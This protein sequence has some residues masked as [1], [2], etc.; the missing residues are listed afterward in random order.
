MR[1]AVGLVQQAGE[2]VAQRRGLRRDGFGTRSIDSR[3]TVT[4][5]R[6]HGGRIQRL[7]H[8]QD[9]G[10]YRHLRLSLHGLG[11]GM[12]DGMPTLPTD[13]NP[14][15]A[16]PAAASADALDH[17]S[18]L[19]QYETDC[20]D[21]HAALERRQT[22]FVVLDVRSPEVWA[23]GHVPGAHSLPHARITER[24]LAS[25]PSDVVFVVYCNGPHCNGADRAAIALA[26][27]GRPVKKMIGGITGWLDEGFAL[28]PTE[29]D[30]R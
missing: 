2:V 29:A 6:S 30:A 27:L 16:V 21:V 18:R 19:L 28:T 14:V 4:R 8:W 3:D 17:F 9:R 20:W 10:D 11:E 1:W 24:H 22:G 5:W 26:R 15:T 23:R 13:S 25:F 7:G 12:I